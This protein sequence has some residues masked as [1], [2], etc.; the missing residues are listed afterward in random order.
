VNEGWEIRGQT[1]LFSLGNAALQT[2][3][4]VAVVTAA[5]SVFG[6]ALIGQLKQ[7]KALVSIGIFV[8]LLEE[9]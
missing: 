4:I 3:D 6:R 5:A 1:S 8:S 2:L 9:C 7:L